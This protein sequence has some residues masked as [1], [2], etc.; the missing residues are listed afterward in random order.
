MTPESNPETTRV[1]G[2]EQ[3]ADRSCPSC[4]GS[5]IRLF[6]HLEQVPVHSVLLMP[7]R[8]IAVNY[9]RGEI[10]L[11]FCESCGFISNTRFDAQK[12]E[13]SGQ[14]EETQGFSPTFQAFHKRL[15]NDIVEKYNVREKTV[16]EIGCGKGEFLALMCAAGQNKGIG[17]DPAFVP[18]R[19]PVEGD[20]DVRFIRD[21]Y[22]ERYSGYKGDFVCCKMTLEHIPDV[23][24]FMKTVRAAIGDRPETTVFFQVPN[25]NRILDDLAFW[26]IYY[27]HCSYFS[28][29]SLA[30]LFVSTGFRV[31]DLETDYDDQYLVIVA[32]PVASAAPAVHVCEYETAAVR[33]RVEH[34]CAHKVPAMAGWKLQLQELKARG[35]RTVLWGSGSKAVAFLTS[36]GLADEVEYVV[37]INPYRQGMYMAGTGQRIVSPEFLRTY[38]PN[39]VIAMNPIYRDEIQ[40]T[41]DSLSLS[42]TRLL[43]V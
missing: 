9:P 38:K 27:E 30:H 26:D 15:A 2:V 6:Y 36:L 20:F 16:L 17:F 32:R 21:F 5:D 37:D 35:S 39:V 13:Y 29:G 18:E 1:E 34:F 23:A 41:L 28:P 4:G 43:T 19:N 11:G 7:T 8:E 25:V 33:A 3:I 40:S 14:Y 24:R 10:S 31:I 42:G 22:S 12:H